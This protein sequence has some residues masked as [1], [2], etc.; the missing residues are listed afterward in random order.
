ML[1]SVPINCQGCRGFVLIPLTGSEA[2]SLVLL[3]RVTAHASDQTV[4]QRARDADDVGL[5]QLLQDTGD[6][7]G[8]RAGTREDLLEDP[9]RAGRVRPVA[10]GDCKWSQSRVL[11]QD[12]LHITAERVCLAEGSGERVPTADQ[13]FS[14]PGIHHERQWQV[15]VSYER[16]YDPSLHRV[17]DRRIGNVD[18]PCGA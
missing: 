14:V 9:F 8:G 2:R 17:Q 12:P 5:D 13:R 7:R 18:E 10:I 15:F 1:P 4:C 16:L 6:K 3:G 11:G